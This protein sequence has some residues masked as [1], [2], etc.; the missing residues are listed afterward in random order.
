MSNPDASPEP[1]PDQL[2]LEVVE[3]PVCGA[4]TMPNQLADGS[5]VCSCPGER[6]LPLSSDGVPLLI[7]SPVD[8]WSAG[9]SGEA[10]SHA[11]PEDKGQFGRDVQTENYEP[12]NASPAGHD[13]RP[14]P[15]AGKAAKGA[16]RSSNP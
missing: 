11:L 16:P 14:Q 2:R 3:C 1:L 6:A 8:D 5:Y 15:E 7:P 12:M 13:G 9:A 4:G 10:A